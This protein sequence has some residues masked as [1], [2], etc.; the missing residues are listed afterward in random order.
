MNKLHKLVNTF[1]KRKLAHLSF[2]AS[3]FCHGY[4]IFT[5]CHRIQHSRF[6]QQRTTKVQNLLKDVLL[7]KNKGGTNGKY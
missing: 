3:I 5:L 6:F 4:Q 1:V 2:A 7:P